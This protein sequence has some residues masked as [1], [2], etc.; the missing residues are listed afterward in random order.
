MWATD[1]QF[2]RRTGTGFRLGKLGER[3][4]PQLLRQLGHQFR[5]ILD[6]PHI[7]YRLAIRTAEQTVFNDC[8]DEL[9]TLATTGV[10][11]RAMSMGHDRRT[12][13]G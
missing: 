8:R 10:V 7:R 13:I 5:V 6:Q 11:V 1:M 3:Q 12:P 4:E 9:R 2:A